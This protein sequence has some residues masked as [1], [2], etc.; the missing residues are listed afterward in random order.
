MPAPPEGGPTFSPSSEA[1]KVDLFFDATLSMQGF[2][3]T[4]VSSSYQQTVPLLER[5]VIE[6]WPG[7]QVAFFKFGD[8]I[9]TLPERK[10][11]EAAKA[12]FYSDTK[13]N[14][15]TLI[16]Q[17][18]DRADLN[19]LTVIITDLFQDNA[20]VN[21][22]SERLKTKF[23]ASDRAV[24]VLGIRSQYQGRV[25][26]VGPD[27]YSFVYKTGENPQTWRPF[28]LLALG[29]HA[30]IA[31]YFA[32][33]DRSG[34]GTFPEKHAL[35]LSRFLTSQRAPFASAKLKTADKIS[36]INSSNLLTKSRAQDQVK[37]FKIKKGKTD[38]HFS[39]EWSY[40]PLPNGLEYSGNLIPDVTSWKGEETGSRELAIVENNQAKAA[41]RVTARLLPDNSTFN[42]LDFQTN[43]NVSDLPAPGVYRYRVVLRP[44][45]YS[46]PT[47]VTDWNMRD[48]EIKTWHLRPSDFNGAKTYNLEN[49]LG[50]LRG[51]VVSTTPPE[52]SDIYIYIRVDK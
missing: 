15:K 3:A 45:A 21:Q 33:L 26:D 14:K 4:D 52:V 44:S 41:L 11:L 1:L 39:T 18:I 42:K 50:T 13:Y 17:V 28:Y 5:A 25:Y 38:A 40:K 30:N 9:A 8:E 19:H 49:F 10:Y 43:L 12:Q 6:G 24:G 51:A 34:M 35:I 31:Q 23:I 22:L 47:W 46:L 37:A 48:S 7:G 36:E 32:T 2:A 29:S 27:N 16:E 20:D